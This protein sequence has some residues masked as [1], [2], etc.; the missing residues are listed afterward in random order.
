MLSKPFGRLLMFTHESLG[1]KMAGPGIRAWELAKAVGAHGVPVLLATPF[2]SQR[3]AANVKICQYVW[4]VPSTLQQLID[5]ADAVMATGNV[6]ARVVNVLGGP[7]EKPVIV[8]TYYLP[9]VEQIMRN[10]VKREFS[11]DPTPAFIQDM[12]VY[13]R[14]GDYFTC[15]L[16]NQYDYWLGALLATGRINESTLRENYNIEHMLGIVPFGI[17]DEAPEKQAGNRMKGVVPGI[18][19]DDKI[20]YWGGG[21]WDWTDPFTYMEALK[22][23]NEKRGDV[24]AVFGSLHHFSSKI[25]SEMRA[26]GRLVEWIERE[27]WLGDKV[28]FLDWVNYDQRA[29]Y[30]LESD[31]G[32]FLA[33]NTLESRFAIRS[34]LIDHL[35]TALPGVLSKGDE[36]A[37]VLASTGLAKLIEPHD[38]RGTADAIL[39]FLECPDL[40]ARLD[41]ELGPYR[42]QNSW[43]AVVNPIV[44]FMRSPRRAP[45]SEYARSTI[46]YM[47]PLRK[48]WEQEQAKYAHSLDVQGELCNEISRLQNDLGILRNSRPVRMA[49]AIGNLLAKVGI[50]I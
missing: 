2:P 33:P 10:L 18:G 24:R 28:F 9:E 48:E 6:I 36:M 40:R 23:V 43:F 26:A 31:L 16:N 44:E 35:W 19:K 22:I 25:V 30:L 21:I 17:P 45:D 29:A 27:N 14:Q 15:A 32:I 42:K 12:F 5:R 3:R 20:L 1:D 47:T 8:D 50:K 11:F 34:R 7:I 46:R 39:E 49:N 37:N 13:L 4:E 41:V 38:V